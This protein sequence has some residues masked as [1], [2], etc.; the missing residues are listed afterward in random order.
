MAGYT[1]ITLLVICS[2]NTDH[3]TQHN[4]TDHITITQ[5]ITPYTPCKI[6]NT[7][8]LSFQTP[9]LF[10]TLRQR[11]DIFEIEEKRRDIS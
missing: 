2:H 6:H 9:T 5:L 4:D 7:P 8:L 11:L 10:S 3:T 1:V